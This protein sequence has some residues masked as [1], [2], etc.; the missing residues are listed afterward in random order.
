MF[1]NVLMGR[2]DTLAWPAHNDRLRR[3]LASCGVAA[4][5]E[6]RVT[7]RDN[8]ERK[9]PANGRKIRK[10]T[11]RHRVKVDSLSHDRG[12]RMFTMDRMGK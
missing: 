1:W 4:E 3:A 7:I 10:V 6:P 2:A 5:A 9:V 12:W 8:P 11:E